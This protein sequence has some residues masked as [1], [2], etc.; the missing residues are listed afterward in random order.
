MTDLPMTT[1]KLSV[2]GLMILQ[3]RFTMFF[4]VVVVGV[5]NVVL[6]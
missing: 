1:E 6:I 2:I 3:N 4:G 5:L